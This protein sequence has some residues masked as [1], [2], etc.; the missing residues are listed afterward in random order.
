MNKFTIIFL[1]NWLIV[2]SVKC[3]QI[4]KMPIT[5]SRAHGE[6]FMMTSRFVQTTVHKTVRLS[7]NVT[8]VQEPGNIFA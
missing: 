1:I 6:G 8:E 5:S 2:Q 3:Q 7:V 4:M